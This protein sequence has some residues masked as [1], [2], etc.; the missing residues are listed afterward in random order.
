MR[1]ARAQ[2]VRVEVRFDV[3]DLYVRL[4]RVQRTG[5]DRVGILDDRHAIFAESFR[6]KVLLLGRQRRVNNLRINN[7]PTGGVKYT[8]GAAAAGSK[9]PALQR[10]P[11]SS[12]TK[13]NRLK[14]Q[15]QRSS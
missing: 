12:T 13:Q 15:R 7:R 9:G 2:F 3:R 8:R 4:L 10:V 11:S 14:H 1:G 5:V 6:I